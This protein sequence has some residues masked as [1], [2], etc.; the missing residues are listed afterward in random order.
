MAIQ[1]NAEDIIYDERI[2]ALKKLYEDG[3][4]FGSTKDEEQ[5]K[6]EDKIVLG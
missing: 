2:H 6:N 4:N 5:I 3:T 1:N